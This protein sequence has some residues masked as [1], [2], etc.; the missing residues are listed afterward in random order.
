M[1]TQSPSLII[2]FSESFKNEIESRV[3]ALKKSGVQAYA[4]FDADGTLWDTD[5][6]ELFFLYQIKNCSLK[7][8]PPDPWKHYFD[9]KA[10][11]RVK[12]YYWLAQ[13]NQGQK[14]SQV[15][16]WAELAIREHAPIPILK[17][18][19]SLVEFLRNQ[20]IEVFVVT[21]SIKWA[22][23]PAAALLG[24]DRAHVL[25]MSTEVTGGVVSDRPLPPATYLQGKADALMLATR[26]IAPIFCAGNTTGDS[27]LLSAS[28]GVRLAVRTQSTG[29]K[30]NR[31]LEDELGLY[32]E[33]VKREWLSHAFRL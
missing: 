12:A 25:G 7:G 2:E 8:L 21:A 9:L 17:S 4:A 27:A 33:A 18:M 14:L 15:Q 23:E 32:R 13:I 10:V 29:D 11:D 3:L 19:A 28:A 31:L 16:N 22:V 24:I 30:N 1:Q 5:I 6:G 20:D 26:G